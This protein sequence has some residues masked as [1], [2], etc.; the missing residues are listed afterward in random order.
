VPF[1]HFSYSYHLQ[2]NQTDSGVST[3]LPHENKQYV[4][5]QGHLNPVLEADSTAPRP[6]VP[7]LLSKLLYYLQSV[8]NSG[9]NFVYKAL[10][11]DARI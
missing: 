7:T 6:S 1:L 3:V 9:F 4:E 11:H 8:L 5:E 2:K 10:W